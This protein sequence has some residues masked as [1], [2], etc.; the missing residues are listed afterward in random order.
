M[1]KSISISGHRLDKL[2]SLIDSKKF[3][4][5]AQQ[6]FLEII[7]NI[8]YIKISYY[9]DMGFRR[10]YIGM[11]NGI[12]LWVGEIV[13]EFKMSQYPDIQLIAVKPFNNHGMF[14]SSLDKVIYNEIIKNA[15]EVVCICYNQSKFAYIERDR[16]M[17]DNSTNLLAFVCDYQSGT[18]YTINYAKSLEKSVDIVNLES[19]RCEYLKRLINNQ[20]FYDVMQYI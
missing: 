7:K 18:G 12:D 6:N 9:I 17:V 3:S 8:I 5:K 19:L 20:P 10:F 1:I 13:L 14:F 11:S 4:V 2:K 16:Y 15:D